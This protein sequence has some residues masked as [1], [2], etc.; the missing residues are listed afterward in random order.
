ME[1]SGASLEV[2]LLKNFMLHCALSLADFVKFLIV[3]SFVLLC[4]CLLTFEKENELNRKQTYT[5]LCAN[6][7]FI[8]AGT[9]FL[10]LI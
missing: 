7:S 3:S 10:S 2:N 6:A 9:F 5:K 4:I 1:F 8:D